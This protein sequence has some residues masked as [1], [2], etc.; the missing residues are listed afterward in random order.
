M[1]KHSFKKPGEVPKPPSPPPRPP[2]P[3]PPG[4]NTRP[5]W[6]VLMGLKLNVAIL[7]IAVVP[8]Y[9]QAQKTSAAR[10][11]KGDAQKVVMIISGYKSKPN[12][13]CDMKKLAW[14]IEEAHK[15]KETTTVNELSQKIQTLEKSLGPE[16]L[17]LIDGYQNIARDDQL[18]AEFM[19]A[20]SA[21]Y[22]LCTK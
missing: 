21:L 13:Y 11:R 19:S 2:P 22:K 16:Y 17:A 3:P 18:G 9:A 20:T 15:K 6:Y 8:V 4:R 7:L 5:R 1:W 12:T 14:Q 10:G